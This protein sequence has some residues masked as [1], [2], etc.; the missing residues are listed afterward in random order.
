MKVEHDDLEHLARDLQRPLCTVE[1]AVRESDEFKGQQA[2][3]DSPC[4]EATLR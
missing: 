2:W 1:Q 3:C 4:D